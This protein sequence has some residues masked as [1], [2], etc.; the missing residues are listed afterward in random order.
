MGIYTG[1]ERGFY[2]P[3]TDTQGGMNHRKLSV[4]ICLSK[5]TDYEGG[6]FKLIDLD[7][8]F[9]F[10]KGT[11]ILFDS[12]LLHGVEPVTAGIRRVLISFMWDRDGAILRNDTRYLIQK[13]PEPDPE[14]EAEAYAEPVLFL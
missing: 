9:K 7:R 14:A 12:N 3:H 11:A 10:D 1:N 13:E 6:T 4:V 5:E 8:E 2:I